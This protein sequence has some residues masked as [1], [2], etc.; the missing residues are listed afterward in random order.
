M[1]RAAK[2]GQKHGTSTALE[3]GPK[4]GSKIT[5]KL[6]HEVDAR[7]IQIEMVPFRVSQNPSLHIRFSKGVDPE[8][9]PEDHG[10]HQGTGERTLGR[11]RAVVLRLK[12]GITVRADLPHFQHAVWTSRTL[13]AV[14]VGE[15]EDVDGALAGGEG[16]RHVRRRQDFVGDHFVAARPTCAHCCS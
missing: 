1:S 12:P 6:T 15:R 7:P 2:A 10:L 13:A 4:P 16:A 14:S 9:W 11:A 8:V 3:D 5:L